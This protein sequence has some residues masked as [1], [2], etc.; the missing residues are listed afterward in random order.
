[1]SRNEVLKLRNCILESHL[2]TTEMHHHHHLQL[3]IY[4]NCFHS[5]TVLELSVEEKETTHNYECI[6]FCSIIKRPTTLQLTEHDHLN[7]VKLLA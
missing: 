4:L 2:I 5:K 3:P 1:M 7:L 6:I